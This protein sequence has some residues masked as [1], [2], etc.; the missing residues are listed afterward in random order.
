M[1]QYIYKVVSQGKTDDE[2]HLRHMDCNFRH[3]TVTSGARL[4]IR[5]HDIHTFT[6]PFPVMTWPG[7]VCFADDFGGLECRAGTLHSLVIEDGRVVRI[8]LETKDGMFSTLRE[9]FDHVICRSPYME[10]NKM[11]LR[12]SMNDHETEFD[13]NADEFILHNLLPCIQVG[14]AYV[15]GWDDNDKD[16]VVCLMHAVNPLWSGPDQA[17]ATRTTIRTKF[18]L[19][20][21]FTFHPRLENMQKVTKVSVGVVDFFIVGEKG[22]FTQSADDISRW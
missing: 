19:S 7:G 22:L 15:S 16:G 13:L 17:D 11:Y 4:A 10:Y 1:P 14:K 3:P 9:V 2:V 5:Q 21:Y 20:D 12:K 8:L 18:L 6:L